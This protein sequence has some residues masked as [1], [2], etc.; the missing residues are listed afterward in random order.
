MNVF[1]MIARIHTLPFSVVMQFLFHVPRA[2]R[3]CR[4]AQ[5]LN[6][7]TLL[8]HHGFTALFILSFLAATLVPLGSEWL[9]IALIVQ[10]VNAEQAV[11]VAT[12]GNYLGACTTYAIGLWG[13]AFLI[14]KILRM[15]EAT[16]GKA[17]SFYE[18]Y[19]AWALLFSWLP[20]IGDALCL[21]GGALRF[22]FLSF[23]TLVFT[24]K[25]IRYSVVATLTL[26]GIS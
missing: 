5:D 19:G 1:P 13:S 12:V 17:T 14:T 23:S 20:I 10:S 4:S 9:L 21:I 25:L 18:K 11:L 26:A 16:L 3:I 6:V 7:E 8:I 15:D 2:K 22:N 24:G